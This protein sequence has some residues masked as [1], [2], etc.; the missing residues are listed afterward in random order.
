MRAPPPPSPASPRLTCTAGWR[1]RWRPLGPLAARPQ[2]PARGS[3]AVLLNHLPQADLVQGAAVVVGVA[4]VRHR[5][6]QGPKDQH[7]ALDHDLD[8]A[9]STCHLTLHA[10]R[11][12]QGGPTRTILSVAPF[13]R[14][15]AAALTSW[16]AGGFSSRAHVLNSSCTRRIS[17][18]CSSSVYSFFSRPMYS[19]RRRRRPASVGGCSGGAPCRPRVCPWAQGLQV[20]R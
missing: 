6:L 15:Q 2:Q 13:A 4:R 14:S 11:K 1:P 10:P 3:P 17:S 19:L 12:Q 8:G 9:G 16:P 5:H 18:S 7:N 20:Q